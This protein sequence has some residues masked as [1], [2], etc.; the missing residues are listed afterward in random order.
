MNELE[1]R[2]R[3][4]RAIGETEVPPGMQASIEARLVQVTPSEYPRGLGVLAAVLAVALVGSLFTPVLMARY[5]GWTQSRQPAPAV[6]PQPSPTPMAVDATKCRLPVIAT[7]ESGPPAQIETQAGF[8]DTGTGAFTED[9]SASVARLPGGGSPAGNFKQPQPSEPI[10]YSPAFSRWLPVGGSSVAPDGRSYLWVKLLPDGSN[11]ETFTG[12]ELHIYDLA[13]ARDRVLWSYPGSIYVYQ[14]DAAGIHAT[15]APA[16]GGSGNFWLIDPSSGTA[17]QQSVSA[18]PT[19]LTTLPGDASVTGA[20]SYGTI[21]QDAQGHILFRI[22][23]R[24]AGDREWIF[25]ESAPGVRV[26]IYR[27]TQG[28]ATGF[29]P[30]GAFGDAT[31]I[32][33]GDYRAAIWH[34]DAA[35]GLRKVTVQGLPPLPGGGANSVETIR[36]AGPCL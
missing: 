27:G 23:S 4:R 10:Q 20:V 6:I 2:Q 16:R 21:G 24:T 25:F 14:W 8:V 11:L 18:G 34:W 28:D 30:Y 22:G 9:P 35:T 31:G 33:F 1:V 36:P 13:A 7:Q 17:A 15:T 29:D 32:W 3:L 12:S 26:T 5:A 19:L